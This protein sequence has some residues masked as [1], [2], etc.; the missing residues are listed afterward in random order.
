[1]KNSGCEITMAIITFYF[2]RKM[3]IEATN[4]F[5]VNP[6]VP[7]YWQKKMV[8]MEYERLNSW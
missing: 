4:E 7:H 6:W 5:V 3:I 8:V 2:V 1:M